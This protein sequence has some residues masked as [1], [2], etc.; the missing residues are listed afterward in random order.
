[1]SHEIQ[2]NSLEEKKTRSGT[3]AFAINGR[4]TQAL[5]ALLHGTDKV[6][7]VDYTGSF[8]SHSYSASRH[9][10]NSCMVCQH[11]ITHHSSQ[12]TL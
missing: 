9:R 4:P 2:N 8:M 1:M 6:K 5:F 10:C 7:L 3:K 11:S 12:N